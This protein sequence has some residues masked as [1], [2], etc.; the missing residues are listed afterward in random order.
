[1]EQGRQHWAFQRL[2]A[3][4]PPRTADPRVRTAVDAFVLSRLQARGLGFS[5][6]ADRATL[7]RRLSLD[8]LGLPPSPQEIVAFVGDAGPEAYERLV[9]RLLASPHFGER[10]GRHWLDGAGYS[11]I[12]GGDND[13]AILK[14]GENKWRYRDYVVASFNQDKPYDRFLTEQLAG[15]ELMDWRQAASFTPEMAELLIATGYLR[16]SADNTNE[17][18]LNSPDIR[19]AVLQQ[20]AEGVAHDLLG[21]TLGCAKCHTHK[22]EPIP[23]RDYYGFVALFQPAFNPDRWLQPQNRQLPAIAPSEKLA[24][25]QHNAV[26]DEQVK[27]LQAQVDAIRRDSRETLLETKLRAIPEA[28]RAAAPVP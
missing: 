11:D 22:Y 14:I 9:E 13:A 26:L 15:D 1:M 6:D 21:L 25:D 5:A 8:L 7:L 28:E 20:T 4:R 19:H 3:P 24:I 16:N 27:A 10:W 18:E 12:Y 17:N 23:Q 2:A